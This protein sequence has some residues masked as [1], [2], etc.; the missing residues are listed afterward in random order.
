MA[1]RGKI[2]VGAE[3]PADSGVDWKTVRSLRS[4]P[5]TA[6]RAI[7]ALLVIAV[8]LTFV[9]Y[10]GI[11]NAIQYFYTAQQAVAQKSQLG[12]K[13]FRLEGIVVP[14][15]I[16]DTQSGVDFQVRFANT[17][18]PVVEIGSPPQ[19]FQPTIPVVL[20]GHFQGNYFWSNQIMIKHTANYVAAHPNRIKNAGGGS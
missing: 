10:K 4:R 15:S 2:A 7:I 1:E 6:T 17:V 16:K 14:G 19:L 13:T 20:V 3:S 18:V 5:V 12:S 11:S 8:A 9:I